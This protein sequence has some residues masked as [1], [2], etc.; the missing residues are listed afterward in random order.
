M[1]NVVCFYIILRC[2]LLQPVNQLYLITY[3][4]NFT[5]IHK[6]KQFTSP[7]PFLRARGSGRHV[8]LADPK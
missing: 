5:P 4:I 6:A 2:A 8:H 3:H 7:D 1:I